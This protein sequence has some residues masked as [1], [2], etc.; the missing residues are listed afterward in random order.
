MRMAIDKIKNSW[1]VAQWLP[2]YDKPSLVG[3]YSTREQAM[4]WVNAIRKA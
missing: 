3:P 2:G 4:E 1:Y